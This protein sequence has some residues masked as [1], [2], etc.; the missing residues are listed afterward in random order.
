MD[1]GKHAVQGS[2]LKKKIGKIRIMERISSHVLNFIME[3]ENSWIE[4][5]NQNDLMNIDDINMNM[6]MFYVVRGAIEF[7][8]REDAI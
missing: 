1:H 7:T 8:M 2:R 3:E 6:D 5:L 4:V